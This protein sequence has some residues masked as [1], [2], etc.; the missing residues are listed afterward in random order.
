MAKQNSC[1]I[2]VNSKFMSDDGR[3]VDVPILLSDKKFNIITNMG[4]NM[5]LYDVDKYISKYN[6]LID[7]Q[8]KEESFVIVSVTPVDENKQTKDAYFKIIIQ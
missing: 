4:V 2:R 5:L 3:T 7:N 1:K 6:E 8:W